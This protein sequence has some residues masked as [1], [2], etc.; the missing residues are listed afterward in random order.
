MPGRQDDWLR[1]AERD[2]EHSRRSIEAA[3]FEWACFAAH[4]AA[5]KAVKAV[6]QK[7]GAEARG[8]SITALLVEL[9]GKRKPST[10][11]DA[12]KE[13][14]RHYIGTRYPDFHSVG[15]PGDYYTRK[16][17]ERAVNNAQRVIDYCKDILL[18]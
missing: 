9:P 7:L 3:D 17:A 5:E 15:A 11:L 6:Y 4:Q 12:S 13:L 14:D 1:Q 18:S 10:L 8:H 2:L 16:D